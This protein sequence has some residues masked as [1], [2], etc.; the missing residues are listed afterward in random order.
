MKQQ[1]PD[2]SSIE[3]EEIIIGKN[4]QI[5]SNVQINVRGVFKI[6]DFG[7]FGNDVKINAENVYIGNH[8]FH[9]TEGLNVGGGG[10]QFPD[11]NFGVG[12]RCVVHN[13]YINLAR[14]VYL[15]SDVG[16]SPDVQV[17]THG[18]WNSVLEGY[19]TDYKPAYIDDGTIVG[20]RSLIIMAYIAKNVVVGAGSVVVGDLEEEKAIY[21]GNPAKFIR[22]ITEPSQ[23][24]KIEMMTNILHRY[25]LLSPLYKKFEFDYPFILLDDT[26]INL[27]TK[28]ITG[29]ENL[30][31]DK[32]RD[33][34]RRYGIRI[35]TERPFVSLCNY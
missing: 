5:G 3:A 22:R 2:N 21:A 10:S 11:A 9:Y 31:T 23:E 30:E 18:F 26:T 35:Y 29:T 34:L 25:N 32:L 4:F 16:L 14:E 8:F 24:E 17:I 15:G 13:N 33:Y 20:Q 12:D 28:Q 19:P 27:E 1:F 7:H 6:G